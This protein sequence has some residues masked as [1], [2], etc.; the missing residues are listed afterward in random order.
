MDHITVFEM[1]FAGIPFLL[2]KGH[3]FRMNF[4][5][6]HEIEE[7]EG[8]PLRRQQPLCDL[9][10]ELDR[11]MPLSYEDI[12]YPAA[13]LGRNLGAIGQRN[14]GNVPPIK[15]A[16]NTFYYPPTASKWSIFRGLMRSSEVKEVLRLLNVSQS[17]MTA[18]TFVM[19]AVPYGGIPANYKIETPMYMLPPRCL[20]EHGIE[21]DGLYLIT[22]VD[23]RYY[24][25]GTPATTQLIN[26]TT[27]WE[28]LI[29]VLVGTLGMTLDETLVEGSF[30]PVY[31]KPEKDS[32]LWSNHESAALLLDAAVANV[33]RV[34]VRGL[35]GT[36]SLMAADDSENMIAANRGDPKRVVRV[37]GGELFSSGNLFK[38][39]S[40]LPARNAIVP[41]NVVISYPKYVYGDDPVPHFM[42][43][44]YQNQRPSC[45]YEDSFGDAH[46]ITIPISSGGPF[47]SGLT[48]ISQVVLRDTAKALYPSESSAISGGSPSNISGLTALAMKTA[49][50]FYSWQAIKG[51][52]ETYLGTL[53]I[54]PDGIHD[55]TWTYSARMKRGSTRVCRT[56]WTNINEDYQHSTPP[57][58]G[59]SPNPRGVGGPSV[60]QNW[61][62]DNLI[63]GSISTKL[64]GNLLSGQM[65]T[66]LT[67]PSF[68]PTN[69]RW[70]GSIGNEVIL[71]EGTSGGTVTQRIVM[72]GIDGTLEGSHTG[73]S[74]GVS[75]YYAPNDSYGVNSVT[76]PRGQ[77]FHPLYQTS[78][79]IQGINFIPTTQTVLTLTGSGG[80]Y[81]AG[82]GTYY[83]GQIAFHNPQRPDR[84]GPWDYTD[85]IWI[86]ERN[87]TP[88]VS[89][90]HYDGQFV[91]YSA[92]TDSKVSAPI[93]AIDAPAVS[94]GIS[95]NC[96]TCCDVGFAAFPSRVYVHFMSGGS[97]PLVPATFGYFGVMRIVLDKISGVNSWVGTTTDKYGRYV[98]S[99][100]FCTNPVPNEIGEVFGIGFYTG[101]FCQSGV[102]SGVGL[103]DV[104]FGTDAG[105]CGYQN[106][107]PRYPTIA[108]SCSYSTPPIGTLISGFWI[109]SWDVTCT[110]G[111]QVSGGPIISP[112]YFIGVVINDSPTPP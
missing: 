88:L 43:T 18:G 25:Q 19:Q 96:L 12:S 31:G 80:G 89:G 73:G 9:I 105:I 74:S 53:D 67:N 2:D 6:G 78:G 11:M 63:S 107:V 33:G 93:Y 48:G 72:R 62:D 30:D 41:R 65:T 101:V 59:F 20:G 91:G 29:V 56:P 57:L 52:D 92:K 42:N 106:N 49:E 61:I 94:S 71:F 10:D 3:S 86:I 76:H 54:S 111:Q 1:S 110:S 90:K 77:F 100:L 95:G 84:S 109:G 35:D 103:Q 64:T 21:F 60:A 69:N 99:E 17:G 26:Y 32:Q 15:N 27:T 46:G 23:D 108:G 112:C 8:Q 97:P 102:L 38:V 70:K 104:A 45:W 75:L 22:L 81:F 47:V 40:L 55:I 87:N 68:F 7:K 36:Y 58:E 14:H 28:N 13:Y 24:F 34:V 79:G 85:L 37:A 82:S 39:G 98:Q 83:S 16:I 5:G 4:G 44:R 50:N 66:T 51:L